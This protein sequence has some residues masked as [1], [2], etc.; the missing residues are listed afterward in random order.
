MSVTDTS[1]T[2]GNDEQADRSRSR[3]FG[4]PHSE[5][6]RAGTDAWLGDRSAHQANVQRRSAGR[7][8]RSVSRTTQTGEAGLDQV[9]MG[10]FGNESTSQ[11]LFVDACRPQGAR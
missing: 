3:Y 5:N 10:C 1:V 8:E 7:S 6:P 4:P 2:E 9:G 11:V